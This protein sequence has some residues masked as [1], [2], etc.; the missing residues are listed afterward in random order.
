[1]KKTLILSLLLVPVLAFAQKTGGKPAAANTNDPK[2]VTLVCKITAAPA[3]VDTLVLYEPAGLANRPVGKAIRRYSD[4]AYVAVLPMSKTPKFYG[5]SVFGTAV[6]KVILGTEPDVTLWGH[7]QFMEKARCTGSALNKALDQVVRQADQFQ[8]QSDQLRT[9]F[10]NVPGDNPEGVKAISAKIRALGATKQKYVDSVKAANPLL[11][12]V[13]GSLIAPEYIAAKK[14]GETELDFYGANAMRYADLNDPLSNEN[15]YI[16]EGYER[17]VKRLLQLNIP[18]DRLK[19][20]LD[21]Q[22]ESINDPKSKTHRLAMA[23]MLSALKPVNHALYPAYTMKYI[24]LYRNDTWGEI[25]RMEFEM[26]QSGTST[27]GFEAPDLVGPTPDGP[28][29]ALSKLRGKVVLVDFWASWC[30]PCRRENPNVVAMYQKYKDKG[31]EILGVSLDRDAEAWK[32]AIEMDG[33]TW[34]H[35][36]DLKGWQS[37][38]AR[39]YSVNSIPATVLVDRDGRIITRNLRG[40]QLGAK[41]KEIFGE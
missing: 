31:F 40:E 22:M 6:G 4:S 9:E 19:Y 11:G 13:A 17:F 34:K 28:E 16:F 20:F 5:V 26:K 39:L 7:A 38:H 14:D 27:P 41:L 33:L 18:K 30:G 15:P 23:G 25:G 8:L 29:Y 21:Y 24:D 36:S 3:N 2:Q 35:I 10:Y 37:Q 1:M 32:K 12:Q